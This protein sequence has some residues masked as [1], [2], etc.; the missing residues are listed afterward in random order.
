ML[1]FIRHG[2]YQNVTSQYASPNLFT[3][4]TNRIIATNKCLA[5]S[6]LRNIFSISNYAIEGYISILIHSFNQLISQQ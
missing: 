6:N 5:A 3:I 1:W 4:V 2:I